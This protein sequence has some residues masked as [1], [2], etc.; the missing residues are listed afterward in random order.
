MAVKIESKK[1]WCRSTTNRCRHLL[2]VRPSTTHEVLH[3]RTQSY[4]KRLCSRG[5]GARKVEEGKND[6]RVAATRASSI[7][8]SFRKRV[9][10]LWCRPL[11]NAAE[12]RGRRRQRSRDTEDDVL[13]RRCLSSSTRQ[14][15]DRCQKRRTGIASRARHHGKAAA[16]M[17][18]TTK[19]QLGVHSDARSPSDDEA[20]RETPEV[21]FCSWKCAGKW[22]SR[23]SPIQTRHERGIRIDIAAGRVVG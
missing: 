4:A 15:A 8:G 12:Q 18:N 22:N 10:C 19:S 6:R 5:E 16:N 7:T 23:Y 11:G 14:N 21:Y 1:R 20:C 9:V 3:G 13:T 17:A 2:R